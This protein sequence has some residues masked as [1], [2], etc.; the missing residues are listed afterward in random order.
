M[1]CNRINNL[2][3]QGARLIGYETT[4]QQFEALGNPPST[5]IIVNDPDNFQEFTIDEIAIA[6]SAAN[7][8][9]GRYIAFAP[10]RTGLNTPFIRFT[11]ENFVKIMARIFR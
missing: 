1:L 9:V 10:G 11:D 3:L 8:D 6:V 5:L 7:G 4:R 2:G